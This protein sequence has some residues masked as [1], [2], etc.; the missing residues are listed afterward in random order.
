MIIIRN[1]HDLF[2][3][4]INDIGISNISTE[5]RCSKYVLSLEIEEGLLLWNTLTM[6][7]VFLPE[8]N[9]KE[10]Q[11]GEMS[12]HIYNKL[13]NLWFYV[14]KDFNEEEIYK[15]LLIKNRKNKLLRTKYTILT[16]LHCNANCVY[17][18]ERHGRFIKEFMSKTIAKDVVN[19][20]CK[21]NTAKEIRLDWMGG[22]PLL[23]H[24]IIDF[25]CR[26]LHKKEICFTSNL[27]TN[28]LKLSKSILDKSIDF[29]NLKSIQITLDG[30]ENNYNIIKN[31]STSLTNPF[32]VVLSNIEEILK[33]D[34]R[35]T[36]RLNLSSENSDDLI[37][38]IDQLV[39]RF[40]N[41]EKYLIY[42]CF[43]E[44]E[45]HQLSKEK[46]RE[47]IENWTKLSDKLWQ[48]GFQQKLLEKEW[49]INKCIA[50]NE[51]CHV[52]SPIGNLYRCEEIA[53]EDIV[54]NIY[55]GITNKEIVEKWKQTN[56]NETC[57]TCRI[58]PVC[59]N[60]LHCNSDLQCNEL[61]EYIDIRSRQYAMKCEY[62]R[63]IQNKSLYNY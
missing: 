37:E 12:T 29:W 51:N 36:I 14:T 2:L 41:T 52:I 44:N 63:F 53:T 40:P 48:L 4:V 20:I 27:T 26:E 16:T 17:C 34:I 23:N 25:I 47:N 24:R 50:D 49:P 21:S 30:T 54:G 56:K 8:I 55:E 61:T 31:Y 43:L 5:Y 7:F 39:C 3:N 42:I 60:L 35:L 33:N 1:V 19:F 10:W 57:R 11:I 46:M 38:L 22:E 59:Y 62:K 15:K 9:E 6:G 58:N 45:T 32:Q 18:Y 28:G 13:V